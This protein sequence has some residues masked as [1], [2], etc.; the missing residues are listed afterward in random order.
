M[1][2]NSSRAY[3]WPGR[4]GIV[5]STSKNTIS[6]RSTAETMAHGESEERESW[7]ERERDRERVMQNRYVC[8]YVRVCVYVYMYV[9][10]VERFWGS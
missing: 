9:S 10:C 6:D 2:P 4:V 8:M 3:P 1:A 5:V 7:V